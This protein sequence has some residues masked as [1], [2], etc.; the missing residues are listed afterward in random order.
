MV[1]DA[2]GRCQRRK[3]GALST[4]CVIRTWRSFSEEEGLSSDLFTRP[5]HSAAPGCM[6][7]SGSN[8][9]LAGGLLSASCLLCIEWPFICIRLTSAHSLTHPAVTGPAI[10]SDAAGVW[11]YRDK[12]TRPL[13]S[14]A[15]HLDRRWACKCHRVGKTLGIR[16][17]VTRIQGKGTIACLFHKRL[18]PFF[19]K[20][21]STVYVK[22]KINYT[23]HQ[24]SNLNA[25]SYFFSVQ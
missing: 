17:C 14:G 8:E 21:N 7:A 24:I 10:L 16:G 13:H 25:S 5:P 2:A 9:P 11:A 20:Q 22:L 3:T 12:Q 19:N 18:T 6:L 4:C 1:T 23:G 15:H